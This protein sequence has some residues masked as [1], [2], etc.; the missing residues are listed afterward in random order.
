MRNRGIC[1]IGQGGQAPRS[2]IVLSEWGG[3]LLLKVTIILAPQYGTS[4]KGATQSRPRS[5]ACLC[6]IVNIYQILPSVEKN[7]NVKKI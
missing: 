6:S 4:P 2:T 1:K 3:L 5:R 7:D